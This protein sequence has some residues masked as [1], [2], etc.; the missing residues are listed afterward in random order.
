[1]TQKLADPYC[2]VAECR[3]CLFLDT[4]NTRAVGAAIADLLKKT[5][6]L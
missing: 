1:M 3:G 2:A 4:A 5:G 6:L